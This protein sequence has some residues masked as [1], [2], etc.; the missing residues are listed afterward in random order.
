[1][2]KIALVLGVA[3]FALQASAVA[4]D[5]GG[6]SAPVGSRRFV[7]GQSRRAMAAQGETV[8]VWP[9]GG[10]ATTGPRCISKAFPTWH[11]PPDYGATH[12]W[13]FPGGRWDPSLP[14]D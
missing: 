9:D 11:Y 2:R 3:L 12:G 13:G 10:Y 6:D 5:V 14:R 4:G 1:M 7:R 8:T